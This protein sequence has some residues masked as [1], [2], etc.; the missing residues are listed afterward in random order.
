MQYMRTEGADSSEAVN[1]PHACAE[2]EA[3]FYLHFQLKIDLLINLKML[4]VI[5]YFNL[6]TFA[7][8]SCCHGDGVI[9]LGELCLFG[10]VCVALFNEL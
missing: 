7:S 4:F 8:M 6:N 9:P 3:L 1:Q 5:Y 2:T 10:L